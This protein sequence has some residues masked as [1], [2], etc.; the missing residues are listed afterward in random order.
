MQ[1]PENLKKIRLTSNQFIALV[2]AALVLIIGLCCVFFLKP[3]KKVDFS[4]EL[5]TISQSV[6]KHYQKNIDY[7]GLETKVIAENKVLPEKMVRQNKLYSEFKAEILVGRNLKGEAVLPFENFF[8]ITYLNI[9]RQK[10]ESLITSTFDVSSGL[11]AV[12]VSN[13]KLYEFT[14]GGELSL[15]VSAQKAKDVCA[16]KNDVM[17]TFE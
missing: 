2:C 8:N 12:T 9:G 16:A 14:Y 7:R 10:C 17:I 1:I 6:R 15:P 13:E 11:T 3:E 4:Q 5:K